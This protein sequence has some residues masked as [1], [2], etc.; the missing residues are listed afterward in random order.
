MA[1]LNIEKLLF[2]RKK[3]EKTLAVLSTIIIALI[4]T[5]CPNGTTGPTGPT[6]PT[7]GDTETFTADGV[8]YVMSYVPGGLIFPTGV[9]DDGSATVSNAYWI[10]D[11]ETTYE[12]WEKVY[13]WATSGTGATGAGGYT[14]ANVGIMG[15]GTG[16]TNQHPVTTVDWRDSMVWCNALTEWYNAQEGTSCECV[17]TYSSAVIRDSR[18]TNA[19]ACDGAVAGTTADG[20]RL[21]TSDEYECAARYRNGTS[22]TYGDHASGDDSGACY[23]DGNILG[24]QSLSTVYSDYA[25]Y[26]RSSTYVVGTAGN[27]GAACS[28]NANA[29]GLYDLSGNVWEWCFD[30]N[31][32][33]RVVRGGSWSDSASNLRVG[34]WIGLIPNF[35]RKGVGFRF[36]RTAN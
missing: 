32:S 33:R 14:F 25:W 9:N 28:G 2:W 13:T 36:A 23:D 6:G 16:D 18:D 27:G 30:L 1:A 31:E 5:A 15:D 7:A 4:T 8:S 10:A 20:F 26:S 35:A 34:S 12:L 19:T 11:T 21:L 29:L 3:M 22:W 24:G 17:Y